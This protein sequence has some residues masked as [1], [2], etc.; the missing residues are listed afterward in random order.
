MYLI[1]LLDQI[2]ITV[3]WTGSL[4][5]TK[6]NITRFPLIYNLRGCVNCYTTYTSHLVYSYFLNSTI[7][8]TNKYLDVEGAYTM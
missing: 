3:I 5:L 7:F 1:I 8:P 2:S 6:R 4:R